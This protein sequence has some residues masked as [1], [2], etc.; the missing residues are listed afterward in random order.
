MKKG[1]MPRKVKLPFIKITRNLTALMYFTVNFI[2]IVIYQDVFIFLV[3]V[4]QIFLQT[5]STALNVISQI[6]KTELLERFL[7]YVSF[8]T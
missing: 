5:E 1:L 6:D 7:H 8:D 4:K 2:N 3:K